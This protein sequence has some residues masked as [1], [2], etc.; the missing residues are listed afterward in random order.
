M[1]LQWETLVARAIRCANHSVCCGGDLTRRVVGT[2]Y[3]A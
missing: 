3:G 1:S 2:S